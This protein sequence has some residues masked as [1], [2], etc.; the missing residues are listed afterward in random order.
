MVSTGA[1]GINFYHNGRFG[2]VYKVSIETAYVSAIQTMTALALEIVEIEMG[3]HRRIIR[4]RDI[5]SKC[6]VTLDME[7]MR[8]GKYLKVTFKAIKHNVI[9]DRPYSM[10]IM[11]EFNDNLGESQE[12]YPDLCQIKNLWR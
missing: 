12:K 3:D 6:Q 5:N 7:E 8:D 10:M 4:A 9:P 1:T 11:K 2:D